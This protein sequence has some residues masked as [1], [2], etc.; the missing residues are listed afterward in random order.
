LSS[1]SL[2]SILDS[3]KLI[4][5]DPNLS[6][7]IYLIDSRSKGLVKVNVLG[8]FVIKGEVGGVVRTGVNARACCREGFCLGLVRSLLLLRRLLFGVG[9]GRPEVEGFSGLNL[10]DAGDLRERLRRGLL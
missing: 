2:D 4:D 9:G 5:L 1:P 10:K 3:G 6:F 8:E 7:F